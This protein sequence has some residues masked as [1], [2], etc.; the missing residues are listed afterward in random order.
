MDDAAASTAGE[1][2]DALADLFLGEIGPRESAAGKTARSAPSSA[3]EMRSAEDEGPRLR[4]AGADEGNEYPIEP[5]VPRAA[6]Q[7]TIETRPAAPVL[8]MASD[9]DGESKTVKVLL[10]PPVRHPVLECVVLANLPVVGAAWA[11]QYVREVASAAGKLVACLRVEGDFVRL[12]LVGAAPEG[13]ELPA[14]AC[15]TI[16]S[17]IDVAAEMTDRWIVRCD[18]GQE[19]VVAACAMTRAI[20]VLSG[21]DPMAR[22]ACRP[23]FERLAGVLGEKKNGAAEPM[24]RLALMGAA[25]AEAKE[26]GE[27][28]AKIAE[29]TIGRGVTPVV[30][31]AKI[32][33]GKSPHMLF[34]GATDVGLK[35]MLSMAERAVSPDGVQAA[36][37]FGVEAKGPAVGGIEEKREAMRAAVEMDVE[38]LEPGAVPTPTVIAPVPTQ[39]KP[40]EI[41]E[42]VRTRPQYFSDAASNITGRQAASATPLI[43]SH[44]STRA[45]LAS[46]LTELKPLAFTCPYA[47]GIELAIDAAGSLHL[48]ASAGGLGGDDAAVKSLMVASSWAEAHGSLLAATGTGVRETTGTRPT[49][50][51]FTDR[52]KASRGLLDT[53]VRV[54]LLAPVSMGGQTAWYCTE[55]N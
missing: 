13:V 53:A 32:G 55:L 48:L 33:G 17:A 5:V 38:V 39:P 22:D 50:H 34:G 19:G 30:C 16:E 15:A 29:E 26:I 36:P 44:S 3:A 37:M 54:H 21:A 41:P 18:S 45:S 35:T 49:M 7:A 12:E 52:P 4:L 51:L 2:F 20:T 46:H 23:V 6:T 47:A 1:P 9:E 25:T 8:K 42:P 27:G 28:L 31:S 43:P 24:L 10:P 40:V 11:S 14:E